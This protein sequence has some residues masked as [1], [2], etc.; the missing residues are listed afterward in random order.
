MKQRVYIR[1]SLL[2]LAVTLSFSLFSYVRARSSRQE[3]PTTNECGNKCEGKKTQ[4]EY[5]LWESITRNLLIIK[6]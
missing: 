6:R 1:L 5:I 4:T 2:V 3:D